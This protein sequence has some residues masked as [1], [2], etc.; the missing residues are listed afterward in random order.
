MCRIDSQWEPATTHRDLSSTLCD[1]LGEWDEVEGRE[2]W[3]QGDVYTPWMVHFIVQQNSTWHCNYITIFKR[4]GPR[5]RTGNLR[6]LCGG[7]CS[8]HVCLRGLPWFLSILT[9]DF[10][11]LELT[12]ASVLPQRKLFIIR[13]T[14][15]KSNF[16]WCSD[17]FFALDHSEW[18]DLVKWTVQGANF[19][20]LE[21]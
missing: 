14:T 17:F 2:I 3:E 8:F 10:W 7:Y 20:T 4:E 15:R 6:T 5:I 1:D 18:N 12:L 16:S 13:W 19:E 9:V 11:I 21:L